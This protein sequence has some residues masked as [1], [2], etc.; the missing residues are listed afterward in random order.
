MF[1]IQHDES[2]ITIDIQHWLNRD[3]FLFFKKI[4]CQLK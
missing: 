3:D 1:F 4:F 2:C